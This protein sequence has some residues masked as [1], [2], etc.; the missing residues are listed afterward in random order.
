MK[1]ADEGHL[2]VTSMLIDA[3][4]IVNTADTVSEICSAY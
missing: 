1:A 2:E 3:R 4:A